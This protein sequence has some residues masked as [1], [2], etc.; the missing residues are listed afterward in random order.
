MLDA[1][2]SLRRLLPTAIFA[3]RTHCGEVKVGGLNSFS[4][5]L[6]EEEWYALRVTAHCETATFAIGFFPREAHLMQATT[7]I[8]AATFRRRARATSQF[9]VPGRDLLFGVRR[10]WLARAPVVMDQGFLELAVLCVCPPRESTN[11]ICDSI[12]N[13]PIHARNDGLEDPLRW[14]R[15]PAIEADLPGPPL[16]CTQNI[17]SRMLSESEGE[18]GSVHT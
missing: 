1:L 9:G 8:R 17:C 13:G 7:V 16:E 18:F 5:K 2:K 11:L 12:R 4:D 6:G 3:A 10:L 14:L 15:R